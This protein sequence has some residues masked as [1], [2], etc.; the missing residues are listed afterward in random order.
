MWISSDKRTQKKMKGTIKVSALNSD[1][2]ASC[3][4]FVA[5]YWG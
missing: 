5:T 4:H 1:V 3:L 2:M